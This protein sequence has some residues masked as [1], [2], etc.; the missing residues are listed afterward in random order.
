M[1]DL[2]G[3]SN[4]SFIQPEKIGTFNFPESINED[5]KQNITLNSTNEIYFYNNANILL[6]NKRNDNN[7]K[8]SS[9]HTKYSYDNLKREC[10]HLVI[11]NIMKFI[12]NK[13]YE[14]YEGNIDNGLLKKKLLKL[15]QAQKTNA[16]V[17]FN[18]IFINKTLKDILS[19]NITKQITLY[20][21]DHNKKVIDKIIS[22]KKD[23]FEKIFNLT[24][25]QCLD[26]FIENKKIEELNGLTLYSELKEEII[27]KYENDGESYYENLKLFLKQFQNKINR[28]K[29]R[30]KRKK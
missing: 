23:I 13:I 2:F 27:N 8:Q 3:K 14:V 6:N 30:K 18:K 19:Q 12:N 21:P 17:E 28:A 25:I 22:E 15:N 11:E 29:S 16:D 26:H 4:H 24:F 10:K 7:K 9:K 5:N 1:L 20:E